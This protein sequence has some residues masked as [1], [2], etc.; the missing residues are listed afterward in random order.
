MVDKSLAG[1]WLRRVN[2]T[3]AGWSG[4]RPGVSLGTGGQGLCAESPGYPMAHQ[5]FL[6]LAFFYLSHP[7]LF[8]SAHL[9]PSKKTKGKR[10]SMSEIFSMTPSASFE[11]LL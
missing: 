4:H 11:A 10:S 6:G 5:L 2:P 1:G 8:T 9:F 3:W 7:K